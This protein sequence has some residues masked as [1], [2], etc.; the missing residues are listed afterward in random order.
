MT[1]ETACDMGH[2]ST[3]QVYMHCDRGNPGRKIGVGSSCVFS[4][5]KT[6]DLRHDR[7]SR[8][9]VAATCRL[10]VHFLS[11]PKFSSLAISSQL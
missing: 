2:Y 4:T 3:V 1:F 11:K 10:L 8:S 5:K 9:H 6:L 7:R